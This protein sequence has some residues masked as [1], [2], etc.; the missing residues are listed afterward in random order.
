MIR[1][2][3]FPGHESVPPASIKVPTYV[4]VPDMDTTH[5]TH[6]LWPD[7]MSTSTFSDQ[8]YHVDGAPSLASPALTE[9]LS[10]STTVGNEGTLS[11]R[12]NAEPK[13]PFK[14]SVCGKCYALKQSVG[15]HYRKRHDA[16]PCLFSSCDFKWGGPYDYRHHLKGQHQMENEVIN[17]LLGK[18]AE[19]HCRAT[20]IGRKRF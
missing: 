11:T 17:V 15:R 2:P 8:S 7:H 16:N 13:K 14:C 19:S 9:T 18:T 6:D 4:S 12:S 20:I 5:A 1:K 3:A 10:F